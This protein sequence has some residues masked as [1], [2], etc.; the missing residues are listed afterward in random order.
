[1]IVLTFYPLFIVGAKIPSFH[2]CVYE[3]HVAKELGVDVQLC[4]HIDD[5]YF[6]WGLLHLDTCIENIETK[7][8]SKNAHCSYGP[9]REAIHRAIQNGFDKIN[10][11]V[12]GLC[13]DNL[14]TYKVKEIKG[15][16]EWQSDAERKEQKRKAV[17]DHLIPSI[18]LMVDRVHPI[19]ADQLPKFNAVYDGSDPIEAFFEWRDEVKNVIEQQSSK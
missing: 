6:R 7:V 15:G 4:A 8:D 9:D 18:T 14:L 11:S 10:L 5:D 13:L 17:E 1:M 3:L 2:R 16:E 12:E 19:S